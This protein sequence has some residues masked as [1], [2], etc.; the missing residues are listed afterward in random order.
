VAIGGWGSNL[1]DRLGLHLLTA[2]GMGRGAVD[3]IPAGGLHF[4]AGDV[5]IVVGTVLFGLALHRARRRTAGQ[6]AGRRSP[7][8]SGGPRPWR[9]AG[10]WALLAAVTP[11]VLGAVVTLTATGGSVAAAASPVLDLF[12]GG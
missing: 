6:A 3:F 12:A 5:F 9:R 4:N 8:A 2:P 10:R 11:A 1:L 7:G